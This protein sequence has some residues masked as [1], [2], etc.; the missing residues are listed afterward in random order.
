MSLSRLT[1]P[2]VWLLAPIGLAALA[3]VAALATPLKAP[4]PLMSIQAGAMAIGDE[5]RPDSRAIRPATARGWLIA[6]IPA[7]RATIGW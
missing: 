6:A 1:R 3:L 4:P 2:F 5:G 7:P